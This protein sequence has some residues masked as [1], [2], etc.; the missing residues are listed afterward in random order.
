[1]TTDGLS[2]TR[3]HFVGIGG[4]G[5]SGLARLCRARGAAVTGS[6]RGGGPTVDALVREGFELSM[7]QTAAGVPDDVETMVVSAAIPY[8]HP[9]V[10][11]ATRRGVEV[12][13]YAAMLGRLM[14][15]PGT[16][17][18]AV[19]GTHGKSSTT[20]MLAHVL[21]SAGLDPSVI[22]G[23]RCEQIG[24]GHRTGGS[25]L[26]VAEAC[27]YDRSFHALS[28]THGVILNLEAD[29]LD[30]YDGLDAI[31]ES[32]AVFARKL[33]AKKKG[34][35]LL[36]QHES[37]HRV[38][39]TAGLKCAVETIGFAPQ[40]EWR[41]E[42]ADRGAPSTD[43]QARRKTVQTDR[44]CRLWRNGEDVC[45]WNPPMPGEHMAYNSAVAAVTAHR[46]GANWDDIA[47]ALES[48]TG[49]DRRMQRIG[50][51][52]LPVGGGVEVI[53][54]YGHHP[55]EVDTTLR[56]LKQHHDPKR[57]ICVFQPHQHSRTRHLL[58]QFAVSFGAADL[59]VVPEIYFVRDS[60]EE[61]M[62]VTSATLVE[63]LREHGIN[64]LHIH[65]LDAI[66]PQLQALA[67]DGD[68]VV[69]MGAG[70]VWTVARALVEN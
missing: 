69:T 53:D 56:A 70:D 36:I 63:R 14:A 29:H 43:G 7:D 24:G 6:D 12:I 60:E 25:P 48:F 61:R 50:K 32:F 57:L 67:Q 18:V 46:L 19:A 17:G 15:A 27:E 66:A 49:L 44:R 33:P 16:V 9:E 38:T 11:E 23:A 1:M 37:P 42:V 5:M 52:A 64:A 28:P 51:R 13:K 8:D 31:V 21:I 30:I 54:D 59:V 2:G 20:S 68:L 65:P 40:A 41:V 22:V 45:A 47:A 26:L 34:G 62:S 35:S 39:V 4:S 10:V 3:L 58:D 55:T